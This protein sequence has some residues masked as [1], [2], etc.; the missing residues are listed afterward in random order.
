MIRHL[1]NRTLLAVLAALALATPPARA[2]G[3]DGVDA[4]LKL[5][6]ADT[7]FYGSMLRNR[8]QVEAIAKSKAWAKLMDLPAVKLA[9]KRIEDQLANPDPQTAMVLE[10]LKQPE[11]QELVEVLGDAVSDEIFVYGGSSWV[12]FINLFQ[13]TSNA[14]RFGSA[15]EQFKPENRGKNPAEF[16]ARAALRVLGRN[17]K[18]IRVPDFVLGFKVK[19]AT[20]AEKQIKRLE[21]LLNAVIGLAPPPVRDGFRRVKVG[22]S[23]VLNLTLD[24]SLVPWDELHLKDYEENDGEYDALLAKLR[25]LKLSITVGVHKGYLVLAVGGSAEE[26]AAVGGT[27]KRLSE[28][29]E[30]KPLAKFAGRR[31]TS[32]GYTSKAL[33][34]AAAAT[35]EDYRAVAQAVGEM[36]KAADLPEEQAKKI[37][38]DLHG[39]AAEAGKDLPRPGAGVS[40]A[41]LTER[42]T[43]GYGYDYGTFPGGPDGS[44]PL[45]LT[46]HVG[47]NPILW[48]VGR[49][50]FD[51]ETYQAFAKRLSALYGHAEEAVLTKLDDDQKEQFNAVRK[52]VIPL[53]K[54]LDEI[55]GTLFLPAVR[56]GQYGFVLDAKWASKHWFAQAPETPRALS[57]PEFGFVLGVS[58]EDKFRRAMKG[59]YAVVNDAVAAASELSKGQIPALKPPEPRVERTADATLVSF[60][61]PA[62]LGLDPQV[63]PTGGL[64]QHVAVLALSRAHAE[65]LLKPTPVHFESGPLA[66]LKDKK[67]AG[68]SAFNWPALIDALTPWVELGITAAKPPPVGDGPDADVLKQ[69]RVV[70]EVLKCFRGVTSATYFENGAL[71]T[72]SES[73]VRDLK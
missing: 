38:D 32:L 33:A 29:P 17:V 19:D 45:S 15:L 5:L 56:D 67:L 63:L 6:P 20:K 50:K 59:Y 57:L 71:V 69:A 66:G 34:A 47:G 40:F 52:T 35:A 62:E 55:T 1:K 39:L 70:L 9:R 43:E 44:K 65:R 4:A 51:P 11:N 3:P 54:R 53:I 16:Q 31:L 22:E 60:P 37:R 26:L 25:G 13:Q 30:F 10:F 12:D 23:S 41:F 24:G 58:D 72:H 21:D 2:E 27:G 36:L 68:A 7:A 49:G 14:V 64:S 61:L 48:I 42:G 28:L 46:D 73:V 8:E 18:L